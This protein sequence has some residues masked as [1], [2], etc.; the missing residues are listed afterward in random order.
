LPWKNYSSKELFNELL[1]AKGMAANKKE[2]TEIQT[3]ML[4]KN[5]GSILRSATTKEIFQAYLEARFNTNN[6]L[7]PFPDGTVL[8]EQGICNHSK[9]GCL[10]KYL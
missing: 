1:I 7:R 5:V 4:S 10:Q 6:M 3:N 2:A 8:H 9:R